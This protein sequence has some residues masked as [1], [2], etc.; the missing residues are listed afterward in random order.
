[1]VITVIVISCI[2]SLLLFANKLR[3]KEQTIV[4]STKAEVTQAE[5]AVVA[6]VTNVTTKVG[7]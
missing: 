1:M 2:V 4:A 3:K 6:V 7:L 5:E